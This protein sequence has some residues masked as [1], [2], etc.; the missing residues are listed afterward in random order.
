M[1]DLAAE[2]IHNSWSVCTGKNLFGT[3]IKICQQIL[4]H[5]LCCFKHF[6]HSSL[7]RLSQPLSILHIQ[8]SLDCLAA[9]R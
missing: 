8:L 1:E 6:S 5:C 4:A 9:S 2:Y 7:F 3:G